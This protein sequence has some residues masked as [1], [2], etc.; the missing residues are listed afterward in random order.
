MSKEQRAKTIEKI[1]ALL[2][3]RGA[4]GTTAEEV[5]AAVA[6]A[7]RLLEREG[8]TE[9]S[10]EIS[11]E[12]NGGELPEGFEIHETT[13]MDE[14]THAKVCA[15]WRNTLSS[16]LAEAFGC[17]V[18][19]RIEKR[20]NADRWRY[21]TVER[22]LIVGR[23]SDAAAVLYLY[24]YCSAEIDRLTRR[25]CRGSDARYKESFRYGCAV[26]VHA[27]IQDEKAKERAEARAAAP[28]TGALIVLDS[29]I[30]TRDARSGEAVKFLE[31]A[32][33]K[34]KAAR[35]N[36]RSLDGLGVA[37]GR[38]AGRGIYPGTRGAK[39]IGAPARM[40]GDGK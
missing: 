28:N 10:A 20:W 35:R 2:A 27:A 16:A 1:K 15:P 29:A 26:A 19:R 34:L 22:R 32:L 23:P 31:N 25:N 21:E 8:L 4:A 30:A 39:G 14:G 33:G 6:L 24:Q 7:A 40:I 12:T 36:R 17:T 13:P 9:D 11:G 18:F 3:K 37:H 5:A 38:E